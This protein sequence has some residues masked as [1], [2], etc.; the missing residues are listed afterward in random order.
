[1]KFV[2]SILPRAERGRDQTIFFEGAFFRATHRSS[3]GYA[4]PRFHMHRVPCNC[5]RVSVYILLVIFRGLVPRTSNYLSIYLCSY[6]SFRV[7]R[8][9]LLVDSLFLSLGSLWG[10]AFFFLFFLVRSSIGQ[11]INRSDVTHSLLI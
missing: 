4:R 9:Q 3:G 6:L 8:R 7:P 1:M 10:C 2:S 5:R 11:L